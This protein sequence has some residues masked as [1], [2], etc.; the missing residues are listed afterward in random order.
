MAH[1]PRLGV[2]VGITAL[3]GC[4]S[5]PPDHSAS[6]DTARSAVAGPAAGQPARQAPMQTSP[7]GPTAQQAPKL[8]ASITDNPRVTSTDARVQT[9]ASPADTQQLGRQAETERVQLEALLIWAAG[10]EALGGKSFELDG[11]DA[12]QRATEGESREQELPE[13]APGP[14]L[15]D[16][17][18]GAAGLPL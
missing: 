5:P 12:Q 9:A 13:E 16:G 3:V 17:A 1:W 18:A 11:G 2:V 7:L 14:V 6:G 4:G 10:D 8:G 15:A